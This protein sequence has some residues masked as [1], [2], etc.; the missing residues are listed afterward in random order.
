MVKEGESEC[1]VCYGTGKMSIVSFV[2]VEKRNVRVTCTACEGRGSIPFVDKTV[3]VAEAVPLETVEDIG[4][5]RDG[6][7]RSK[8]WV[9]T[10]YFLDGQSLCGNIRSKRAIVVSVSVDEVP[11]EEKCVLCVRKVSELVKKDA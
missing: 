6:W 10:H 7:R 1:P 3:T 5:I 4:E 9:K 2:G 8:E 11:S